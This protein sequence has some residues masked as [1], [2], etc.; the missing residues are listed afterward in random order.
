MEAVSFRRLGQ[1]RQARGT[2]PALHLQGSPAAPRGPLTAPASL[3][4]QG[5]GRRNDLLLLPAPL[6]LC[7]RQSFPLCRPQTPV[8]PYF[9]FSV[10]GCSLQ[11]LSSATPHNIV[12][13]S[14]ALASLTYTGQK[15]VL[16]AHHAPSLPREVQYTRT[17]P[18]RHRR[19][20]RRCSSPLALLATR[21][22]SRRQVPQPRRPTSRF[23]TFLV[24]NHSLLR[25]SSKPKPRN[26][27]YRRQTN[28]LARHEAV[29]SSGPSGI[30]LN[31]P[32]WHGCRS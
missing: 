25:R 21:P 30:G 16:S 9:A 19:P 11:S 31:S 13:H 22:S 2:A 6:N 28:D 15:S 12:A 10:Y 1:A 3:A 20:P 23:A 27:P 32:L 24:L 8:A 14:P 26:H 7:P 18:I 4:T 5:G 29:F 17:R